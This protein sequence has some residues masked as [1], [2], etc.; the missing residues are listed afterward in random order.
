[1]AI[2]NAFARE[3]AITRRSEVMSWEGT[4]STKGLSWEC[5]WAVQDELGTGRPVWLGQAN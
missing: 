2:S 5:P 1:M 3:D 4:A